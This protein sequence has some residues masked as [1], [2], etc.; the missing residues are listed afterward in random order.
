MKSNDTISNLTDVS[1]SKE[2]NCPVISIADTPS[3]SERKSQLTQLYRLPLNISFILRSNT[4]SSGGPDNKT[5]GV[6]LSVKSGGVA[7]R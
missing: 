5:G 7:H 1:I 2:L 3:G 4:K 6:G